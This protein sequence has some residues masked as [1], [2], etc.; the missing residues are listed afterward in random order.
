MIKGLMN[1]P[2]Q[3]AKFIWLLAV[4]LFVLHQD[5]WWWS[6]QSIVFG[7]LPIGLAYHAIYSL[8][9]A[10][11]WALAVKFVWPTAWETWADEK[12]QERPRH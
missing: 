4:V 7:F 1:S 8:L 2:N 3:A 12:D 5:Y 10:V 6:D 9:A 11:L